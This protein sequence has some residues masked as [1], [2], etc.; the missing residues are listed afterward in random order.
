[1]KD[2]SELRIK[3]NRLLIGGLAVLCLA[4][5]A[6]IWFSNPDADPSESR[7]AGMLGALIRVGLVLGA[8][9]IALPAGRSVNVTIKTI[10]IGLAALTGVAL[11]PRIVIPILIVLAV[12]AFLI[13]PRKKGW[14]VER[15]SRKYRRESPK[16][17]A[18][19]KQSG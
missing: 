17:D 10:I 7:L 11:R 4:S 12:V 16:E 2:R 6:A 8:L 1:M 19:D 13:M 3:I 14:L 18:R 15:L 9:A 5:A